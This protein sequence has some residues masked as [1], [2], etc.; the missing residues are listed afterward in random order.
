MT[1]VLKCL[2]N[3]WNDPGPSHDAYARPAA[4]HAPT[5]HDAASG[6]GTWPNAPWCHPTWWTDA[7]TDARTDASAGSFWLPSDRFCTSLDLIK[8]NNLCLFLPPQVSENPPNHI[9]FLTNLPEE[10]NELMLSML[11]NQSV[12]SLR[13]VFCFF[14]VSSP[15]NS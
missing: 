9:L 2:G 14:C 11:F 7:W 8:N 1:L 15:I 3:A 10:T 13:H 5:E 12:A 6:D 4:L